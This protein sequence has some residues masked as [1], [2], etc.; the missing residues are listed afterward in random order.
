M[1]VTNSTTLTED[2]LNHPDLDGARAALAA[3]TRVTFPMADWD[4]LGFLADAFPEHLASE[5][6]GDAEGEEEDD[7]YALYCSGMTIQQTLDAVTGLLLPGW[8]AR[9]VPVPEGGL[10]GAQITIERI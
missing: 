1:P 10:T 8:Q 6:L 5:G 2:E 9:E 4:D 7:D 3:E